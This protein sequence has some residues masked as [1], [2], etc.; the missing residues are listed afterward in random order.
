MD[1]TG[2]VDTPPD[3]TESD[4]WRKLIGGDCGQLAHE[5]LARELRSDEVLSW[6]PLFRASWAAGQHKLDCFVA[7]YRDGAY[8]AVV[9]ADARPLIGPRSRTPIEARLGIVGARR[10]P[11]STRVG[12]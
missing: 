3:V 8:Q 6:S 2:R 5:Y 11:V 1:L 4:A 10:P 12:P 7:M 9:G